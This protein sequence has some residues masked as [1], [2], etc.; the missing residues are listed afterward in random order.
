[1]SIVY[2]FALLIPAAVLLGLVFTALGSLHRRFKRRR[3]L[4]LELSW[5]QIEILRQH[6]PLY[7]ILPEDLQQ[8][9]H[10]LINVFLS[11]KQFIGCGGQLITETIRL[12]TAAQACLLLLNRR[13]SF[14]RRLRTVYVYPDTYVAQ[15]LETDGVLMVEGRSVRLGES[16]HRGP[17]VLAWS[18]VARGARNMRDGYNVVLHE[19]AHQLDQENGDANGTPVLE[20]SRSYLR[21]QQVFEAEFKRLERLGRR[22]VLDDYAFEDPAEFFAVAT[23]AFFEIPAEL[24]GQ[25]PELYDELKKYYKVNPLEWK[26]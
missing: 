12:T 26:T 11:E 1:M 20:D 6:V 22:C 9:L 17:V 18:D 8:Q 14:Y 3:L 23:E 15:C 5:P 16:W 4:G 2:V 21:W 7:T 19:F 24:A 10:G 25:A 13:T